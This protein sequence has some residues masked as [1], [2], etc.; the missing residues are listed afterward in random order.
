MENSESQRVTVI[1]PVY[2][3]E[4]FVKEAIDSVLGQTYT[5]HEIILIDDGSTDKSAEIARAY[6]DIRYYY[7][8]NGGVSSALNFGISKVKTELLAFLDSDDYW[9]LDKLEKQ[10]EY[11]AKNSEAEGVF[12]LHKRF[13]HK[14]KEEYTEQ[15]KADATQVY[16][17]R[18][19]AALLIKTAS[20]MRV[21]K[22]DETIKLGDFLDWY[23]R[24]SDMGMQLGLLDQVVFHRRIHDQNTSLK[25]KS[26]MSSYLRLL[27]N[28]MD[29]RRSAK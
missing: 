9:E 19:K 7:Q 23:R 18:F 26:E 28:S 11:L 29:R 17:A 22:F 16:P 24:A 14:P 10:V 20:F 4:R 27:K 12:G 5:N 13:Y 25:K 21:G 3:S 8:E 15:E 2:N 6:P 1:I